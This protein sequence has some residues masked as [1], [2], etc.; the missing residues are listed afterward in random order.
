MKLSKT[1]ARIGGVLLL[2]SFVLIIGVGVGI[3]TSTAQAQAD[4]IEITSFDAPSEANAGDTIS[5]SARIRNTG[6]TSESVTVRYSIDGRV[7]HTRQATVGAG[8]ILDVS[9]QQTVPNLGTGVYQQG[10]FVDQAGIGLTS[11]IRITRTGESSFAVSNLRAPSQAGV[12][13]SVT[14]EALVRNTGTGQGSTTVQYRIADRVVATR[15]LI[16]EPGETVSVSL[17]GNVPSVSVGSYQQGVFIGDTS[18]GQTSTISIGTLPAQFSVVNL[19]TPSQGARGDSVSATATVRNTGSSSGSTDVEYRIRDRVVASRSLSLSAGESRSIT[20][21]GSVPNLATGNYQQGVFIRGTNNGLTSS[22]RITGTGAS[23]SVSDL[24]ATSRAESGDRIT[25]SATVRN[26]GDER[27][28]ETF[29]YRID[30]RE[31]ATRDVTLDAGAR[32]TVT[33][34]G[35]VPSRSSG[36]YRQGVFVE[37]TNRGV[38][39]NLV[40]RDRDDD[41]ARFIVYDLRAPSQAEEDDDITV[42]ATVEN[43]GDRTG[44]TRVEY[45]I[46]GDV[47]DSQSVRI[48]PDR[49]TTVRFDVT[50]PDIGTGTYRQGVFIGRTNRGQ[51]T[52]LRIAAQPRFTLTGFQAPSSVTVGG[53]AS[54]QATIR[55]SGN[56]RTT[57]TVEYRIGNNVVASQDVRVDARSSRTVTLT[58]TVPSV[59]PGTYQQGVFIDGDALRRSIEVRGQPTPSAAFEID[60]L[61]A[62]SEATADERIAVEATVRNTGDGSGSTPIEYRIDDTIVMTKRVTLEAG[63]SDEVEFDVVVPDLSPDTYDHGVFVGDTND[64]ETAEIEITE[65][66]PEEPED[67][68]DGEGMPGFTVVAGMVALLAVALASRFRR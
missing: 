3:G 14:A 56:S 10:V 48:R 13:S 51:T 17:R 50:V 31:V 45:R 23:F 16:L 67:D 24:S 66:E 58:G 36:T 11:Q 44:S 6:S 26:T 64:G 63:A 54:A 21:S 65:P 35:T 55:N 18:Q 27:G 42:R 12:G 34:R 39:T 59:T 61:D 4:G 32:T 46:D 38:S 57:R 62:P 8:G 25:A 41:E 40:I 47:I 28:T 29:E 2:T 7:L 53:S 5:V 19:Q 22:F 33:L 49:S 9:F 1:G 20:L 15:N 30:G 68:E 60:D 37:G 43:V 52:N